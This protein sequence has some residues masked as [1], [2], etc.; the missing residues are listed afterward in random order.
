MTNSITTSS[1]PSNVPA[2]STNR[3]PGAR[4][5]LG[6]ITLY[7]RFTAGRIA[8]CRFYPSC[9]HYAGEAIEVHGVWRGTALALRR[10]SRC[11]PLGPHG[12]DLVPMPKKAR[13][14]RP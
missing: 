7:Q 6:A 5:A 11:R 14:S 4:L 1:R 3:S 13:S 10:L 9:S 2:H 8:P 12:V